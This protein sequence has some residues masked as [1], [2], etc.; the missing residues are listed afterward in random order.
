MSGGG[1]KEVE[2]TFVFKTKNMQTIT[3]ELPEAIEKKTEP[4]LKLIKKNLVRDRKS[5]V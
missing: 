3:E 5:V 2:L 1:N 4:Q